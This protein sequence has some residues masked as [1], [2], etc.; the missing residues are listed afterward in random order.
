MLRMQVEALML[1]YVYALFPQ[2]AAGLR[3][4]LG[5]AGARRNGDGVPHALRPDCIGLHDASADQSHGS[6]WKDQ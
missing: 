4:G 3:L 6:G 5:R 1:V 2:Y